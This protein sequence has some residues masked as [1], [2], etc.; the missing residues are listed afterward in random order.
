METSV[1]THPSGKTAGG[2]SSKSGVP[3]DI[4]PSYPKQG[5]GINGR[6]IWP[7]YII[8][9]IRKGDKRLVGKRLYLSRTSTQTVRSFWELI[10]EDNDFD[11][12]DLSD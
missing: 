4:V 7:D 2:F 5:C 8:K 3:V 9:H 1:A 6:I 12:L 11:Y 10:R